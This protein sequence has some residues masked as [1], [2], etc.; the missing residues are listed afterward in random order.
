M[1]NQFFMVA[2][3]CMRMI[4]LAARAI[5]DDMTGYNAYNCRYQKPRLVVNEEHF[6][7]QEYEADTKDDHRPWA[8]VVLPPAM[9]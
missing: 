9:V 6:Q 4:V 7:N 1:T 5:V 2:V 8:M 3:F